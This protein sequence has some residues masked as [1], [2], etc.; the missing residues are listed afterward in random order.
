MSK[1]VKPTVKKPAA[2]S[3]T[4]VAFADT[5][6]STQDMAAVLGVT[7]RWLSK[8][9][10]D[11]VVPQVARGK[12]KLGD[13]VQS[14]SV[15]LKQGAEKNTGSV[16]LDRLRDEKAK[17]IQL[18]R[19]RKD[20][21]LIDIEE[22]I[23]AIDEITG[24]F[25]ASLNSLPAQITG[26]PRERQRLDGIFDTERQRL[27]DRFAEKRSS[28]LTGHSASDAEAEDDAA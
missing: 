26:V 21:A 24:I 25:V 23:G 14:Y 1:A 22:A 7:P 9:A 12:F 10:A 19:L 4:K 11:G 17:E 16:S 27:A 2:K 20:R 15:F 3:K 5:L 28:L 8:M 6:V 18:N 13:V